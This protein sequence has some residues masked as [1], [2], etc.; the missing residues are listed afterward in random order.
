MLRLRKKERTASNTSTAHLAPPPQSVTAPPPPIEASF[1]FLRDVVL[2]RMLVGGGGVSVGGGGSSERDGC[3][4]CE[5]GAGVRGGEG[6]AV[7]G[8]GGEAG[9]VVLGE[10]VETG[11]E[12]LLELAR[13]TS[14]HRP[15][16][17]MHREMDTSAARAWLLP[18]LSYIPPALHPPPLTLDPQPL[19]RSDGGLRQH[20]SAYVSALDP[21][22]LERSDGTDGGSQK[23]NSRAMVLSVEIKPKSAVLP[24]AHLLRPEHRIKA[25]VSRFRMLQASSNA[26]TYAD[27][28]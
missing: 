23:K 14:Q 18:D 3:G 11:E 20:T 2:P 25:S 7:G 5:A 6:H 19:E 17:R 24:P 9:F 4:G 8:G 10:L 12:F 28:C 13:R 22:P 21:Q 15:P 26:L 1:F 16:A 27:V